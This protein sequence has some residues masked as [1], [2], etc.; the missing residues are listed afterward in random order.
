MGSLYGAELAAPQEAGSNPQRFATGSGRTLGQAGEYATAPR[1]CEHCFWLLASSRWHYDKRW[2]KYRK[3]TK[4]KQKSKLGENR[5]SS[6]GS[7][8]TFCWNI[9]QRRHAKTTTAWAA[10]PIAAVAVHLGPVSGFIISVS[11]LRAAVPCGWVRARWSCESHRSIYCS[12]RCA[13]CSGWSWPSM[14]WSMFYP[15]TGGFSFHKQLDIFMGSNFN[16]CQVWVFHFLW[17]CKYWSRMIQASISAGQTHS[18]YVRTFCHDRGLRACASLAGTELHDSS[19][20]VILATKVGT[21]WTWKRTTIAA[22]AR[23][24]CNYYLATS[25]ESLCSYFMCVT[26]PN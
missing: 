19:L 6:N 18:G 10:C 16:E 21:P 11:R 5:T 8:K 23:L 15:E 1:A 7:L 4:K 22:V 25:C 20:F 17:H 9:D 3:V 14:W 26:S 2:Q 12:P 24:G 13:H